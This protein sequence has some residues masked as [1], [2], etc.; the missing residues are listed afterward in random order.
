MIG[1]NLNGVLIPEEFFDPDT[2]A[3]T[4]ARAST[5]INAMPDDTI[6]HPKHYMQHPSGIECIQITEHMNFCIGNAIKYLWRA[7][8]KN[9][10]EDLEKASWYIKREIARRV[11]NLPK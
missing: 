9:G 4:F 7:D 2:Y 1:C 8:L 10:V 3:E 11:S 5:G 6:N